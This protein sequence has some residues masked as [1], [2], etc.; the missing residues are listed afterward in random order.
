MKYEPEQRLWAQAAATVLLVC[1][2][3]AVGVVA[4]WVWVAGGC[5]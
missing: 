1:L 3:F 4:G 2:V 5:V